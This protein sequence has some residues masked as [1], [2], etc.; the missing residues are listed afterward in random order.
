MREQMNKLQQF[1][2]IY[3]KLGNYLIKYRYKLLI[4]FFVFISCVDFYLFIILF[5]FIKKT[6]T[7]I[8]TIIYEKKRIIS[9]Y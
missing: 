7:Y 8:F 1:V 4:R 3:L 6:R 5:I 2:A 9:W